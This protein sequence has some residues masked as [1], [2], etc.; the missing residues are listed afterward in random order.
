M[1]TRHYNAHR[2]LIL[3]E[4]LSAQPYEFK[5]FD[6]L[7]Y[8]AIHGDCSGRAI[9]CT[10][11]PVS[12]AEAGRLMDAH[13]SDVDFLGPLEEDQIVEEDGVEPG[14]DQD[15]EYPNECAIVTG[16]GSQVRLPV[17]PDSCSY[18]RVID[19]TGAQ[20]GYWNE[21]EWKEAPAEVMG[22][23]FGALNTPAGDVTL[24]SPS[25]HPR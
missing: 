15:P 1:S 6:D 2:T 14:A 8:D 25:K 18:V 22:A 11:V 21:D 23:I 3:I 7:A 24:Q 17:H 13:G 10:S 4:V 16:F 19:A 20:V 9:S 5:G 12:D